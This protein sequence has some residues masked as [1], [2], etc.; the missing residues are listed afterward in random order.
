LNIYSEIQI[1]SK[2]AKNNYFPFKIPNDPPNLIQ[3]TLKNLP[4]PR[5]T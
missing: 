1:I 5:E 2:Q 3:N 4:Y